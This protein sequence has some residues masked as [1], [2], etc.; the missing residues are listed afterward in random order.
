[1][2]AMTVTQTSR[3]TPRRMRVAALWIGVAGGIGVMGMAA[4]P[5]LAA[6]APDSS[7]GV[8]SLPVP[9]DRQDYV[10]AYTTHNPQDNSVVDPYDADPSSI[11][12]AISGGQYFAR[13]YVHLALDYLP[14][15][16]V[17]DNASLTLHVTQ[18]ADASNTGAYQI[19]NVNTSAAIIE[20]CALVTELPAKL[21]DSHPPAYDCEHGSAIGTPNAAHDTWTF[22]LKNLV[23]Y[24]K[25]HGNTGAALIGIGSGD[26][27]QTWQV[28]FYRSRS[29]ASVAYTVAPIA[30]TTTSGGG[31]PSTSA[32]GVTP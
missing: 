9:V 21:D 29:A 27:S 25:L 24:W 10:T 12:V 19:Y 31:A 6:N 3:R 7:A 14:D 17:A 16:A 18:A 20:A 28:A 32:G 11:H 5:G 1:M 30:P 22:T 8:A 2:P 15:G 4:S 23:A 26:Q 13:S